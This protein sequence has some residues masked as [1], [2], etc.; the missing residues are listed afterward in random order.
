[1]HSL[2]DLS[3]LALSGSGKQKSYQITVSEHYLRLLGLEQSS[4]S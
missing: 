3:W 1:M 2:L 4:A